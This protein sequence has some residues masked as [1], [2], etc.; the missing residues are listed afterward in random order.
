MPPS[1]ENAV[2]TGICLSPSLRRRGRFDRV[3]VRGLTA[4][5]QKTHVF[6]GNRNLTDPYW[7]ALFSFRRRS[8]RHLSP[9][10]HDGGLSV[11]L[12]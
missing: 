8:S 9:V 6:Y 3:S 5:G 4:E 2:E 10:G 12:H 7:T 11:L 1:R